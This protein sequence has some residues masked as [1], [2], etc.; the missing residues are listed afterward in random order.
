MEV[1][2]KVNKVFQSQSLIS[3]N[4]IQF[5]VVIYTVITV[6]IIIILSFMIHFSSF[7]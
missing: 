1:R 3:V 4:I 5:L 2:H 7:Q 6:V